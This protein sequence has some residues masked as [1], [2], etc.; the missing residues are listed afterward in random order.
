MYFSLFPLLNN[1]WVPL[2]LHNKYSTTIRFFT[3]VCKSL[4]ITI[5]IFDVF[6]L[7]F[8]TLWLFRLNRHFSTLSISLKNFRIVKYFATFSAF[9]N[10]S[11]LFWIPQH[12]WRFFN[13]FRLYHFLTFSTFLVFFNFFTV[14]QH[15]SRF[16]YGFCTF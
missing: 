9:F 10:V 3:D 13:I 5:R 6:F 11:H 7:F 1:V 12:V 16:F 8:F 15:F 4:K 14:F 2:D